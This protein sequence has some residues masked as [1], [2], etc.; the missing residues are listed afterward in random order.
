MIRAS[1]QTTNV[2]VDLAGLR[3]STADSGVPAGRQLLQLTDAAVLRDP[4]ERDVALAELVAVVGAAGAV[5]AAAVA[6]NFE[7]MNRLLDGIGVGA[8]P[9]SDEIAAEIGITLP[10]ASTERRS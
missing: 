2:A 8:P 3:D 10:G 5:R 4:Y 1:A 9:G 6:G 7:M